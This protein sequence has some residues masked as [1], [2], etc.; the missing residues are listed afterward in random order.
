MKKPNLDYIS[1]T[2]YTGSEHIEHLDQDVN[3]LKMTK[4][5]QCL[6]SLF[7]GLELR[8]YFESIA[9]DTSI[10]NSDPLPVLTYSF[11]DYL[12]NHDFSDFHLIEF[13]SGNSTLYFEKK[14][15]SVI[16]Y[17]TDFS[18]YE[19]IKKIVTTTKYIY[20]EA[21][22]LENGEFSLNM[23]IEGK[24][25]I[26]IDAHCNRY[27]IAKHC[28]EK[29]IPAFVILD[30]SDWYRNTA[31]LISSFNYF[32][33]PFWGHKNN[34]HWES[35]TSLFIS[36]DNLKYLKNTNS[37]RPPLSRSGSNNGW[38]DPYSVQCTYL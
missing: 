29:N 34:E 25:I 10:R 11:M 1:P 7:S 27:K 3:H 20:I 15:K 8:G 37:R 4:L 5:G 36:I 19:K 14:F 12:E 9:A 23:D 28:L 38:D 2:V 32:E 16:S 31:E 35:C 26:L 30:N 6:G 22:K 13:G 17:E 24:N 21:E 18:W 33:V